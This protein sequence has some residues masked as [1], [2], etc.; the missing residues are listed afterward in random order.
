MRIQI[1]E[2]KRAFPNH[3]HCPIASSAGSSG[4][5][6]RTTPNGA[7]TATKQASSHGILYCM[8]LQL[9]HSI[10]LNILFHLIL[11]VFLSTDFHILTAFPT[12]KGSGNKPQ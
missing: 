1:L 4:V 10:F 6:I 5:I 9:Y 12:I 2:S 8:Y 7:Q 3:T 11:S